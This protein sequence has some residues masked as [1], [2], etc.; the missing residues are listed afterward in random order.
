M[1]THLTER[2]AEVPETLEARIGEVK[3]YLV[4]RPT[5][6]LAALNLHEIWPYRDLLATLA[7]RDIK[8]RYKQT[9]LGV[10]WVILQPLLAAGIFS[11][12]FG[13]I[14]NLPSD[15]VPYFLFAYA[16]MQGWTLFSNVLTRSSACLVGNAHLISK[17]YFPRFI[18]PLSTLGAIL[19]DFGVAMGMM[20]VL[21]VVYQV[22]PGWGLLLLPLWMG[23][24]TALG[25]GI[26]LWLAALTVQ[27]RDVAYVLPVAMQMLMYASP[28]A[29]ASSA[30]PERYQTLFFLNPLAGLLD[31]FRWSLLGVGAPRWDSLAVSAIVSVAA[32]IFGAFAFKKMERKFADTI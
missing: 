10:I 22:V 31:A 25:M 24:L 5:A 9:S 21:M 2:K 14:A 16:G 32:L 11:F 18:L 12:V 7:E 8:V 13:S 27:Y 17:V 6:G 29:Y 3:P 30:V 23:I 19:V 4:I 20:A 15:G 26:G 1:Q 28:I